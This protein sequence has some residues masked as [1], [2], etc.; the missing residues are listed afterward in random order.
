MAQDAKRLC[1]L[2]QL[3]LVHRPIMQDLP[4]KPGSAQHC[5]PAVCGTTHCEIWEY[6]EQSRKCVTLGRFCA[7]TCY[8]IRLTALPG[9]LKVAHV[10]R[11]FIYFG[12]RFP[13]ALVALFKFTVRHCAV[14][15][16]PFALS[17]DCRVF[18]PHCRCQNEH[19]G[20]GQSAPPLYIPAIC[21]SVCDRC[22]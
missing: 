1:S 6:Q 15:R 22:A 10:L 7:P 2:L 12:I 20:I 3:L 5:T 9:N 21:R 19:Q 13:G 11:F 14:V 4:S 8:E 16:G 18:W 17:G